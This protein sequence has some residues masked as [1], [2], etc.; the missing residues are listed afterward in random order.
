MSD[1]SHEHLVETIVILG[2]QLEREARNGR[3]AKKRREVA[4]DR[5]CTEAYIIES[6]F[7]QADT[8]HTRSLT[9]T[10]NAFV[11]VDEDCGVF[12]LRST[13]R[14]CVPRPSTPPRDGD[15]ATT[16]SRARPNF[17]ALT[18]PPPPMKQDTS[19][20]NKLT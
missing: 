19:T 18:K 7:I 6:G 9:L 11:F 1:Q 2:L 14:A 17:A 3:N 15:E 16:H 5:R 12:P 8:A 4:T 20:R 10:T 13:R